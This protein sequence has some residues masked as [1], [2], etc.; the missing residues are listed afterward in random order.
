MGCP[1]WAPGVAGQPA[2]LRSSRTGTDTGPAPPH[3]HACFSFP[4]PP[5]TGKGR[6]QTPPPALLVPDHWA[7]ISI[8]SLQ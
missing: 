2:R 4:H 7:T 5:L 6:G 8:T 3:T 1:P